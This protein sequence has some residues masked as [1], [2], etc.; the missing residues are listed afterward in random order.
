MWCGVLGNRS[1]RTIFLC[2]VVLA[3]NLSDLLSFESL[4]C[5]QT[6]TRLFS[7]VNVV[8]GG[9]GPGASEQHE[10]H[11]QWGTYDLSC[12]THAF[13]RTSDPMVAACVPARAVYDHPNTF[14]CLQGDVATGISK[15]WLSN[16]YALWGMGCL[17]LQYLK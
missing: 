2:V 16:N 8:T 14:W 17:A 15:G 12:R 7:A 1:Q 6:C 10:L 3:L 4:H 9:D 13:M 5:Q 11:L